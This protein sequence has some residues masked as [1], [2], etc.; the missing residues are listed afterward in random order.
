MGVLLNFSS[1]KNFFEKATLNVE[2]KHNSKFKIKT[3]FFVLIN[4]VL[5]RVR[6]AH[7]R[8]YYIGEK[9]SRRDFGLIFFA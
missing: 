6:E 5:A 9:V 4:F 7:A 2:I 8:V 3:V 1:F